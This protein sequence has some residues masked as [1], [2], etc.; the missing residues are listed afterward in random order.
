MK[1]F[2][3]LLEKDAKDYV[4]DGESQKDY[5]AAS[6][7]EQKF[8]NLH[9]THNANLVMPKDHPVAPD[10][11]FSGEIPKKESGKGEPILKKYSDFVS[12]TRSAAKP[13]GDKT[14]VMQGSS[15]I[16][17]EV[18]LNE[19]QKP[20]VSSDRDGKHVMNAAGKIVKSFKD[21]ASANAYLK[22]NFNKL[23]KEEA[24]YIDEGIQ[25]GKPY[26][27]RKQVG[28]RDTHVNVKVTNYKKGLGQKDIVYFK[29][30]DGKYGQMPAKVFKNRMKEEVELVD[31]AFKKGMLKLKDGK[32]VKIDEKTAKFLNNAMKQ[33][34]PGNRKKME[35]EAMKDKKS[36]DA[37]V[38]FAK[39]AA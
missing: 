12:G 5:E 4:G 3:D 38:D 35:T 23:M 26:R 39:A 33:L 11:V 14:P 6:D 27:I 9:T 37:M 18:E 15:K 29:D 21:M 30:A 13:G 19:K 10:Y 31:E 28:G 20:Y 24:D 8:K 25:V 17:E 34:N 36:F 1:K 22:K 16:K 2:R 7:D 32:T